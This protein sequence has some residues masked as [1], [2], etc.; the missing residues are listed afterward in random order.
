[1]YW[2]YLVPFKFNFKEWH[3]FNN[4]C[5][6]ILLSK[7]CEDLKAHNIFITVQVCYITYSTHT[8]LIDK[9]LSSIQY[10]LKKSMQQDVNIQF[11][12]RFITFIFEHKKNTTKLHYEITNTIN[13]SLLAF[14]MEATC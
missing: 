9:V 3:E 12:I 2:T 14:V 13:T 10:R 11:C 1:M 7:T 8:F 4:Y 6:D 5:L